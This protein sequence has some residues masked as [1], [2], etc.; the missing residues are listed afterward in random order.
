MSLMFNWAHSGGGSEPG[1]RRRLDVDRGRMTPALG[2]TMDQSRS[3]AA[4]SEQRMSG[5]VHPMSSLSTASIWLK[6]VPARRS[7][8]CRGSSA[9]R[10]EARRAFWTAVARR[11]ISRAFS[12]VNGGAFISALCPILTSLSTPLTFATQRWQGGTQK[13]KTISEP[14]QILSDSGHVGAV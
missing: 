6:T 8:A 9:A 5:S 4:T 10:R 12:R 11:C 13:S 7:R 3:L 14:T 2:R 1:S